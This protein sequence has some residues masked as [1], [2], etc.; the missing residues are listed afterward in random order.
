MEVTPRPVQQKINRHIAV[1][2]VMVKDPHVKRILPSFCPT[3]ETLDS[4]QWEE[5]LVRVER[6]FKRLPFAR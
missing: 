4:V 3:D 6:Q 2:A 5:T 1:L